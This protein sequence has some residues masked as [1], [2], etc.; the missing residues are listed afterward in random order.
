V[1]NKT[2]TAIFHPIS[3]L[4]IRKEKSRDA[5]RSRRSK[6][7]AEFYELSKLLPL[8]SIVLGQLD[9]ASIIRLTVA[10]LRLQEVRQ[11]RPGH[12]GCRCQLSVL[13]SWTAASVERLS[14]RLL[15]PCQQ[16]SAQL[17]ERLFEQQQQQPSGQ[18][19][20]QQL[21]CE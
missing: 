8:P 7:N 5:A 2:N 1:A 14:G 19:L 11:C 20:G 6:E 12:Y 16:S 18:V 17:L 4:E 21:Y 9:K 13:S 15:A 3:I 10:C